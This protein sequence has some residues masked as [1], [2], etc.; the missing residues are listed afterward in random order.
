MQQSGEGLAAY[1]HRQAANWEMMKRVALIRF[2]G[3]NPEIVK[4]FGYSSI[5]TS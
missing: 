3:A 2:E 4:V 1:A 5:N